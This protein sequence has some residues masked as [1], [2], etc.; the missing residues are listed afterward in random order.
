MGVHRN[1]D[2]KLGKKYHWVYTR[3]K[4]RKKLKNYK[5]NFCTSS[6]LHNFIRKIISTSN[7]HVYLELH[8]YC[9]VCHTTN[10]IKSTRKHPQS[11]THNEFDNCIK[12]K[13]T[14]ISP[15][16]FDIDKIFNVHITNQS[17]MERFQLIN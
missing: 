14:S 13:H 12:I 16:F 10:K 4:L 7:M 15:N 3:I 11:L 17:R 9:D 5:N 1:N 8:Y 2:E 6:F